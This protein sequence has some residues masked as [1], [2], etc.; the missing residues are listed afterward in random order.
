MNIP[1]N[2]LECANTGTCAASHYG[3]SRCRYEEQINRR[4]LREF[5]KTLQEGEICGQKEKAI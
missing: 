3:G 1:K 2:C 5:L 4:T